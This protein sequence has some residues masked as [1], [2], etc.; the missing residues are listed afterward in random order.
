MIRI[1]SK[2]SHVKEILL[3]SMRRSFGK[4]KAPLDRVYIFS[5]P[6]D[7]EFSLIKSLV[8][9][10]TKI[11][12]CGEISSEL[13]LFLGLNLG[14]A[15]SESF[16]GEGG[17]NSTKSEYDKSNFYVHYLDHDLSEGIPYEKRYFY[18]YDFTNEW[19]NIGYGR[20]GTNGDIWSVAQLISCTAATPI[21]Y[22]YNDKKVVSVFSSVTDFESSSVL[23][24]NRPVAIPDGLDWKLIENFLSNYRTDLINIPYISD[25]PAGVKGIVSSRLDCDQSI[26][27]SEALVDLYKKYNINISLAISTGINISIGEIDFLKAFLSGGGCIVSHTVNH[28]YGWGKDYQEAY[29]EAITSKEWLEY[30][31]SPNEIK[32]AVSP[33]HSNPDYAVR[34]LADAGYQGFVSGIIHNDP[35]YLISVSGK[36]INST[37]EIVSHSQQCMLHG[38]CFHRNN[39]S[40][41][42]YKE[43]FN[44]H[45]YAEKMFGYLDHPFGNYD[46]G[47]NSETERLSA[48]ESFIKYIN[49][50]DGISWYTL[51]EVLNFVVLKNSVQIEFN[52]FGDV[53][54]LFKDS[55]VE[56]RLY[57][58]K[59]ELIGK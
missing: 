57:N 41:D 45:Y 10:N 27:N 17:S 40:V 26:I 49:S 1:I 32:Y 18:R 39:N 2:S 37:G 56:T 21:S 20:I 25:L 31:F 54:K 42:A 9:Q 4:V 59:F 13:A 6:G 33:F 50:F 19:N 53:I 52:E 47:W 29:N 30:S 24:I 16:F 14:G 46:Y 55:Q 34:A 7:E 15:F 35:E 43:S 5:S 11:I 51:N 8:V 23:F 36:V 58:K 3:C 48:H 44:N 28:F 12:V 22:V 38:D